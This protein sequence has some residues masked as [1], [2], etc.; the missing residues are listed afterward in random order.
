MVLSSDRVSRRKSNQR[1][2]SMSP[3]ARSNNPEWGHW[4]GGGL[5]IVGAAAVGAVSFSSV[6]KENCKKEDTS[7]S[8]EEIP[9][10]D[11]AEEIDEVHYEEK[12]LF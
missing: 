6:I 7:F 11:V 10:D 8:I 12:M 9:D 1:S 5:A 2:D 4:V 3:A